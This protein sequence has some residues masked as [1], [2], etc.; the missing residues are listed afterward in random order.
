MLQ[1][2]IENHLE[3]CAPVSRISRRIDP[4]LHLVVGLI[5]M[6]LDRRTSRLAFHR[7]SPLN[8]NILPY[9]CVF[10][11]D[12]PAFVSYHRRG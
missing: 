6:V 2:L 10:G 5:P 8:F 4:F 3:C 12:H 11:E 1:V 7:S 9:L